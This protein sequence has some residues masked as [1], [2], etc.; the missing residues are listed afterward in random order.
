MFWQMVVSAFFNVHNVMEPLSRILHATCGTMNKIQGKWYFVAILQSSLI[1]VSCKNRKTL[2]ISKCW[3]HFL[4]NDQTIDFQHNARGNLA[5]S[6][7]RTER[8]VKIP[9]RN[10]KQT[11]FMEILYQNIR[12]KY[13]SFI[14]RCSWIKCRLH[15]LSCILLTLKI[16]SI[17]KSNYKV[18]EFGINFRYFASFTI[19]SIYHTAIIVSQNRAKFKAAREILFLSLN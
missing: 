11:L 16:I 15:E 12:A 10:V 8:L 3:K 7:I 17:I 19:I 13:L 1:I 9:Y 6:E 18:V 4:A 2:T 5:L 14:G